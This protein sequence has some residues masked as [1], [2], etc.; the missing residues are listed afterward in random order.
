MEVAARLKG[1]R[2]SAQ[3][4]RLVADQVRGMPVEKALSLLEFSE[5]VQKSIDAPQISLESSR[6]GIDLMRSMFGLDINKEDKQANINAANSQEIPSDLYDVIHQ[7]SL[8]LL[9][10]LEPQFIL[11]KRMALIAAT[12]FG[13]VSATMRYLE[14]EHNTDHLTMKGDDH[15]TK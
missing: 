4:A 9:R 15:E 10:S 13:V 7:A 2:I 3:K 6:A 14:I 11:D 5:L 12:L 1:A 8:A